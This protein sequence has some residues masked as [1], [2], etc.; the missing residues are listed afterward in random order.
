MPKIANLPR[1]NN[2]AAQK[3]ITLRQ[4]KIALFLSVLVHALGFLA[5]PFLFKSCDKKAPKKTPKEIVLSIE[6]TPPKKK[7]LISPPPPM[8]LPKKDRKIAFATRLPRRRSMRKR[9]PKRRHETRSSKPKAPPAAPVIPKGERGPLVTVIRQGVPK[10]KSN[11]VSPDIFNGQGRDLDRIFGPGGTSPYDMGTAWI[12][13]AGGCGDGGCRKVSYLGRRR[14]DYF[15]KAGNGDCYV[16][17][18]YPE[19]G[20]CF[21]ARPILCTTVAKF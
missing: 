18:H 15:W 21:E 5:S 4:L 6:L 7:P 9:R 17:S 12:P 16:S 1:V 11:Y 19:P 14:K 2:R 8:N 13:S 3:R 20:K 10:T